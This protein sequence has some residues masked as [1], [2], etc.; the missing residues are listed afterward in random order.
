[1]F[2]IETTKFRALWRSPK[3]LRAGGGGEGHHHANHI[4]VITRVDG[5]ICLLM[6]FFLSCLLLGQSPGNK[7]D[8]Y[9]L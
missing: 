2:Q 9:L 1:M 4:L 5:D 7:M 3:D 6:N 8:R